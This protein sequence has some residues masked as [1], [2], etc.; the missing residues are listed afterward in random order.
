MDGLT[1]SAGTVGVDKGAE[2][3][4]K[5]NSFLM[6]HN[7]SVFHK[8]INLIMMCCTLSVGSQDIETQNSSESMRFGIF[9]RTDTHQTGY[10]SLLC[11]MLARLYRLKNH[12]LELIHVNIHVF[13]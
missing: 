13:V 5:L 7:L 10:C 4:E 1:F 11:A 9:E 8:F 6:K 2:W 3:H 12:I